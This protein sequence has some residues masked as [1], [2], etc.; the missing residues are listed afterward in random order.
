MFSFNS[1]SR[2]EGSRRMA[3]L[4]SALVHVAAVSVLWATGEAIPAPSISPYKLPEAVRLVS[5]PPR[6]YRPRM[7]PKAR[8]DRFVAKRPAATRMLQAVR[9]ELP[10]LNVAP[11]PVPASILPEQPAIAVTRPAARPDGFPQVVRAATAVL[12]AQPPAAAFGSALGRHEAPS[13]VPPGGTTS[14]GAAGPAKTESP[15]AA[16]GDGGFGRIE[17]AREARRADLAAEAGFGAA[18]RRL[19]AVAATEPTAKTKDQPV[20]ILWKPVPKY[21]EEGVRRRVEGEVVLLVRFLA[22]G[23]AE[24]LE[25]ISGL[26]YGL[27]EY[28]LQAAEA[29]RFEP[30]M[31]DDQSVDYTAQVRIRFELAY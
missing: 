26:G 21:S 4:C 9:L 3:T 13:N 5:P 7:Q 19:A 22:R 11:R 14:F 29:I 6:L 23:T 16:I 1:Q 17:I 12:Q 2:S 20:K 10:A 15:A 24:T 25:V 18:E 27:D 30:A 31:Q 28:A 8:V